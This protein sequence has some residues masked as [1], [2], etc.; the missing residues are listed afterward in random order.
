MP[1]EGGVRTALLQAAERVAPSMAPATVGNTLL[2]LRDLGVPLEGD[3]RI[4]LLQAAERVAP[5]MGLVT[6]DSTLS[7]LSEL[8]VALDDGVRTALLQ[9][10][11]RVAPSTDASAG[12]QR[13]WVAWRRLELQG[14]GLDVHHLRL[15]L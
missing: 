2:G 13:A 14:M 1:L 5:K 9:A 15:D 12:A 11:E 10:L 6:V 3:A 8:N 4:A 7:G